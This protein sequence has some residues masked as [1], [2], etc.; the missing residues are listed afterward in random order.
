MSLVT[1]VPAPASTFITMTTAGEW[2]DGETVVI[3]GVT[4][5]AKDALTDTD[6]F[7]KVGVTYA[8]TLANLAAAINLN[9]VAGTQYATSQTRNAHVSAAV[10]GN[11][12]VLT[13]VVP[14]AQGNHIPADA[15]TSDITVDNATLE[16]GSGNPA[17]FFEELF[18][19]NQVN[20]E[21]QQHLKIFTPA[22]D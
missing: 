9:G 2:V 22:A 5:T 7:V 14:G 13:A 1:A 15:G 6:G 4:Y 8:A 19:Y 12:V 10:S 17:V 16:N 20:S 11:D 21:V 3:G 18:Q